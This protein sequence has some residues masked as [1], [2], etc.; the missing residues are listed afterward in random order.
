MIKMKKNNYKKI[1][2]SNNLGKQDTASWANIEKQ[3]PLS[4]VGIPNETEV[5]NAK[6]YVDSNEK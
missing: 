1:F 5:I 4:N 2:S 6:E 3:K